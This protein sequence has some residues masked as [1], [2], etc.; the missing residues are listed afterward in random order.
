MHTMSIKKC[1]VEWWM[2]LLLLVLTSYASVSDD[3]ILNFYCSRADETFKS[4]DPLDGGVS[5]SWEAKS[6]YKLM[7]RK[8]KVRLVDSAITE[9]FYSFGNVDS[10]KKIIPFHKEHFKI[11]FSYPNVFKGDYHFN[12]FPN[13]TGGKEIA[14]GFDTDS[15]DQKDPVGLAIID[16][17]KYYLKWLY[18]YYPHKKGYKRYTRSFRFTEY[19][20]YIF[21][22]SI[23]EIKG[24]LSIFTMEWYRIETGISKIKIYR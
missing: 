24:H 2:L 18:L 11:D 15:T 23:W 4:R 10:I 19:Q 21:P 7:E 8:G 6:Y 3:Q 12:F 9:Y 13:D 1:F 22:D 14:I 20:G 17:D 16:R 5:F